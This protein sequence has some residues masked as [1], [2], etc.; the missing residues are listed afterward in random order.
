MGFGR[1]MSFVTSVGAARWPTAWP[2]SVGTADPALNACPPG[3][4]VRVKKLIAQGTVPAAASITLLNGANPAVAPAGSEYEGRTYAVSVNANI[5]IDFGEDGLLLTN[6]LAASSTTSQ[7]T[8][9]FEIVG[10]RRV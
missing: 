10:Q 8:V 9:I 5:P 6:G 2:G 4:T 3:T 7:F 1:T